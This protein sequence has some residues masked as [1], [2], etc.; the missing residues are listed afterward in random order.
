MIGTA[1]ERGD[2]PRSGP[3]L[4]GIG[5]GFFELHPDGIFRNWNIANN[6]PLGTGEPF[7]LAEDSMLFFVV[8]CE[9]EGECPQMRILQIDEGYRVGAIENHYYA[10]P[11]LTGVD[12]IECEASFPFVRMRFTDDEMPLEVEME[13]WSPFI[14]HDV[15]NSSLPAAVFGFRLRP[16][17]SRPVH[18]MLIASMHNAVGYDVAA[19][20][21]HH[22]TGVRRRRG[23]R[24]MELTEE[25]DRTLSS[26]GSQAVASL[27]AD[28]RY[29]LGWE[30]EHPYYEY[31]I[32]HREL[33]DLDD[34]SGRNWLDPETGRLTA[35]WGCYGSIGV[36]RRLKRR[37]LDHTFVV[38]WHFPNLYSQDGSHLEGHYYANFFDSATEVADY[39]VRSRE[40]LKARTRQF[41]DD[42]RDSS[43]PAFVLD[44]VNS[45]LNTFF[46][47]SWLTRAMDFGIMEGMRPDHSFGPLATMDV[48]MYG[49]MSPAALFP[50]LHK[51][52]MRAHRRMQ[53][54]DGEV[55]HGLM[56]DFRRPD[57]NES[58]TSRLDMPSQYVM[59]ALLGY[60]WT[61]DRDYLGEMWPSV[62]AALD[63]VLEKRD[64][65]GDFLPDMEGVMCSYDNFAMWGVSSY[66]ASLWLGALNMAA[67]AAPV[68]GDEEAE[69]KYADVLRKG[70]AAFE[71]AL[72]T[73]SYYRLFNDTDGEHGLDD[74]C[75]TDQ[76]MGE[77]VCELAGLPDVVRR[78]RVRQ[79][80]RA[81]CRISRQPWGLVNC[82]WPDDEFLHPVP[83]ECWHDQANTPWTGV[84]LAFASFLL[85]EGMY[86]EALG[87]IR[88]VDERYRRWGMYWDHVEFGGHYYR[89]M[90]AWA[91]VNGLLGLTMRGE[92]FGFAPVVPGDRLRLFFSFGGGTAHYER[93]VEA[94]WERIGIL[95]RT[96]TCRC[97][98]LTFA[99]RRKDA[100]EVRVS[101][102]GRRLPAG[103]Y[104]ADFSGSGLHLRFPRPLAVQAGA[105]LR[106]TVR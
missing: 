23:S 94:E 89:P 28:S 83:E 16:T 4:G 84:E 37:G 96:G 65:N 40:D 103:E 32:R 9:V 20:G 90:S 7:P 81:I 39:V 2:K 41:H 18:V 1:M 59:L 72:W 61:G 95:V 35:R 30:V 48:S 77:W 19:E 73:G 12:R 60:F 58:V 50:E 6:V 87:V 29:Y 67:A 49:A 5:A 24:V 64:D 102:A 22:V 62:K 75:L 97:R 57:V 36:S 79:A 93:E 70:R 53:L 14:P 85:F 101:A 11:W 27:A 51:N 91:I 92:V 99:L 68:L 13:A 98:E 100:S 55:I 43:A 25:M 69:A 66:V 78:G 76:L 47:S 46:T 3:A 10:F 8:R 86:R 17:T 34:T 44:Q 38:A 54:P 105:A 63:Y 45:Q 88:N 104:E 15:K 80:L 26:F 106:L 56:K 52:M 33:P 31:L 42:F 21:K 74:G 71:D 82:R